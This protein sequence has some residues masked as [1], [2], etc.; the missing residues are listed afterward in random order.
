MQPT[1]A[2]DTVTRLRAGPAMASGGSA[3]LAVLA[4]VIVALAAGLAAVIITGQG[5]GAMP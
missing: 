5:T 4:I 1:T 3:L 2:H